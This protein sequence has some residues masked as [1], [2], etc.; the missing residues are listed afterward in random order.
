[1]CRNQINM[2]LWVNMMQYM[3]KFVIQTPWETKLVI[4]SFLMSIPPDPWDLFSE[5]PESI[6][7]LIILPENSFHHPQCR[8]DWGSRVWPCETLRLFPWWQGP[9]GTEAHTSYCPLPSGQHASAQE[10]MGGPCPPS[11]VSNSWRCNG[12]ARS[13]VPRCHSPSVHRSVGRPTK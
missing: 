1:M 5:Q 2:A 12:S 7:S 4:D 6:H 13:H 8:C 3:F 11:S 10:G 9:A